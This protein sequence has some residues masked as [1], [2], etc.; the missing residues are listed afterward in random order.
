M[1]AS[2]V[3]VRRRARGPC[4]GSTAGGRLG[5]AAPAFQLLDRLHPF[6]P[7]GP[8]NPGGVG[9]DARLLAAVPAFLGFVALHVG[10]PIAPLLA[11]Q[12]FLAEAGRAPP[13]AIEQ[14]PDATQVLRQLQLGAVRGGQG[15]PKRGILVYCNTGQ[16]AR[17]AAEKLASLGFQDVVYIDGSYRT[18]M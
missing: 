13:G 2:W 16:R 10:Q 9:L 4:S 12:A 7:L 15:L 18:L 5:E 11:E 1:S 17:F 14:R 3:E 6:H 8:Q